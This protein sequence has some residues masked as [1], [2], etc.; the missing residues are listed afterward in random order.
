MFKTASKILGI[1]ARNLLYIKAYNPKEAIYRADS[2]LATKQ[3]L[4]TRGLAVPKFIAAVRHHDDLAN[5]NLAN[6]PDAFVLKPDRG[7]GGEGI[8]VIVKREGDFFI[9]PNGE[10]LLAENILLHIQDIL[11]GRFSLGGSQ[12]VAFFEHLIVTHENLEPYTQGG[13]PDIRVIVHNLVPVMAMMRLP[14]TTSDGK[15]NLHLGAAGVGIDLAKGTT[16]YATMYNKIVKEIPGVGKVSGLKIPFWEDILLIASQA[17][18]ATNLGYL[19]A[20]IALDQNIGPVLLE[21]NARAGLAVQVANL[22]FLRE[23]LERVKGLKVPNPAK[24]VSIARDLFGVKIP[25]KKDDAAGKIVVGKI[26]EVELILKNGIHKISALI[27]LQSEKTTL[28]QDIINE[29]RLG[30]EERRKYKSLKIKFSLGGKRITTLAYAA[31]FAK[32]KHKMIISFRDL[33]E[34]FL[35][36]PYKIASQKK[37]TLP[38]EDLILKNNEA[39]SQQKLDQKLIQIDNKLADIDSKIHLLGYLRPRNLLEEKEKFFKNF[40]KSPIFTYEPTSNLVIGLKSALQDIQIPSED[41][42]LPKI[43]RDKKEELQKKINFIQEINTVNFPQASEELYGKPTAELVSSALNKVKNFYP[44]KLLERPLNIVEVKNRIE[45]FLKKHGLVKSLVKIKK[46][47]IANCQ[48]IKTGTVFLSAQ[49]KISE[50]HLAGLIAH[51][52]EGHLFRAKNGECQPWK[53][54]QRGFANYLAT[55]EGLA[56][57]AQ[58]K[59]VSPRHPKNINP[60]LN[61]LAVNEAEKKSFVEVFE[62]LLSYGVNTARAWTVAVKVKRGMGDTSRPGAFTKDALYFFGREKIEEFINKDGD[63]KKLYVGK[64]SLEALPLVEK[65][66]G[67]REPKFVP[68]WGRPVNGHGE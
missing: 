5:L 50:E 2:K 20:D 67:I 8:L 41:A 62:M 10:K 38:K 47:M 12:D 23:R 66:V 51:E 61:A 36:N 17:Q 58:E 55:E 28:D 6:F 7:Y 34:N 18:L 1:N 15:A 25:E 39:P 22:A 49:A 42:P 26:E 46:D 14:T 29:I 4:S 30:D 33:G 13:L 45:D 68:E 37:V 44:E 53:I 63:L 11:D 65:I 60:A 27:S 16:T 3:F 31:N 24:G 59:V 32:E 19:A 54:F 43:F 57:F 21:I 35:I 52:I 9:K 48:V 40:K 64:I 56:I